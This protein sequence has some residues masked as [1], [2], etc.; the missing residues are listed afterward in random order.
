MAGGLMSLVSVGMANVI[1]NGNPK[2]TF[3]R[4]TYNKYTH[5]GMQRFRVDYKGQRRLHYDEDTEMIFEVPRYAD[6]LADTYVVVNLPNIWSPLFWNPDASGTELYGNGSNWASF[7]FRWI[8]NLGAQMIR[9]IKVFSGGTTL[10]QYPGEWLYAMKERDFDK[11]KKNLW[12][13]M[14]G[15]VPELNDPAKFMEENVFTFNTPHYPSIINDGSCNRIE[16]SIRGRQLYIPIDSWFCGEGKTALPLISTQYQEIFIKITFRPLCDLFRI[17][18]VDDASGNF[19]YIAPKLSS[20]LNN[21]WRFLTPPNVSDPSQNFFPSHVQTWD[22]D[23]HLLANYIFLSNDERALFAQDDQTYLIKESRVYD[24]LNVT[25]STIVELKGAMNMVASWMWRFRRSD[26]NLRNEWS[27]YSNW[28]YDNVF[29]IPP[30]N[31]GAITT[32]VGVLPA[33]IFYYHCLHRE[34]IR[35]ILVDLAIVM[36]GKYREDVLAAGMWNLVEKYTRT[37]GNAKNGLYCYNFCLNSNQREYQPSGAMNLNKFKKIHF[38]FNTIQPP[39]N[40]NS[41]FDV[42]C[43]P[44]GAIIGV[45]KEIWRQNDY[46]FDLRIFE[47]RYN[48]IVIAGGQIGLM[49]AR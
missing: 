35:E 15:G 32:N 37:T 39:L 26:A 49:F 23:I 14:V 4:A 1:L 10:A 28:A 44:S 13:K 21:I 16:P 20:R 40:P 33:T 31:S 2:K 36:D 12:N 7:D 8:D 42:I 3:F 43:D 22:A 18:D 6:L 34:N 17:R 29:P 30:D 19:P 48:V 5:F 25:G 9:E 27:N 46:N 47:E 24:F 38:E 11:A 45:R 41:N